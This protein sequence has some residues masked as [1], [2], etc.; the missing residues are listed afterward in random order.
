[1][2][3]GVQKKERADSRKIFTAM[4]GEL[5]KV[6]IGKFIATS[7]GLGSR[8]LSGQTRSL[9]M[10]RSS[11]RL[12]DEAM[13]REG[14]SSLRTVASGVFLH[15]TLQEVQRRRTRLVPSHGRAE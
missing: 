3:A 1:M 6:G 13:Q 12:S 14:S 7:T 4:Y 9:S 10:G 11:P 2:K 15:A 5:A 8:R